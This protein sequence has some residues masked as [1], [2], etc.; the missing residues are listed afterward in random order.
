MPP[1]EQFLNRH[2][3]LS[4]CRDNN[5]MACKLTEMDTNQL[6][7]FIYGGVYVEYMKSPLESMGL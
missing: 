3:T 5:F 7:L 1:T 2:G 6:A 4:T